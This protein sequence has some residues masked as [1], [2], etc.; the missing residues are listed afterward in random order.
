MVSF[1]VIHQ[2]RHRVGIGEQFA[3]NKPFAWWVV[4]RLA[5]LVGANNLASFMVYYFQEKFPEIQG[6][7]ASDLVAQVLVFVGIAILLAALPGGW[8]S[9]RVGKKVLIAISGV[10]ASLGTFIVVLS[11]GVTMIYVGGT[12]IGL[13]I[14]LFY[15]S[16]WALGTTIV[17]KQ[18]A[19]GYLGL[20]N[21]AGAG[22]GAIGAYIGGPIGDGAGFTI[23]MGIFG[24]L[25]FLSMFALLGIKEKTTA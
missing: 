1:L 11:T 23:L 7:E 19:A 3:E 22:A 9:D 8:L 20:S 2:V 5:F 10:L 4:S 16:N 21:L 25:F 17:P 12:V 24:I 15:A 14:G 13:A 18:E 6:G